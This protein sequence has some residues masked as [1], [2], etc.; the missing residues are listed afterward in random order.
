MVP[1][2]A[3]VPWSARF[4][5]ISCYFPAELLFHSCLKWPK[6]KRLEPLRPVMRPPASLADD[7]LLPAATSEPEPERGEEGPVE[8]K[9]RVE[10]SAMPKN[11]VQ[12]IFGLVTLEA[13]QQETTASRKA[14]DLA[15]RSE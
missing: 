13:K 5:E 8:L 11:A 10:Y 4:S 2:D 3:G 15:P 1:T 6:S 14:M 9:T 12:S 7:D